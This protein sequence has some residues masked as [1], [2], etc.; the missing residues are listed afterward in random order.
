MAKAILDHQH[1]D[2]YFTRSL[3]KHMLGK[4]VRYTDM[5]KEDNTLYKSLVYLLQHDLAE[6]GNEM[7][8]V[9]EVEEFGA[10]NTIELVTDGKNI[11]V[12]E[13]NKQSYVKFLCQEKMTGLIRSQLCAFLEGF[14]S[15]IPK[16]LIGIFNENELELLISGMPTIDVDNLKLTSVYNGFNVNSLQVQWLWQALHSFDQTLRAKFLQFVT[17]TSK[18]PLG[19]FSS[20]WR[21]TI[22]CDDRSTDRLPCA[23]TW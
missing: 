16:Q 2:C 7:R 5:E 9:M 3:Y 17:G 11:L 19:G 10:I 18:V 8:F 22:T 15:L 14:Y 12:T 21:L 4:V 6:V 20:D 23:H 1:L 13:Q